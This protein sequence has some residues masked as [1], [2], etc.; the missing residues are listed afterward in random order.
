VYIGLRNLQLPAFADHGAVASTTAND[1]RD[2]QLRDTVQAA[3][4]YDWDVDGSEFMVKEGTIENHN[5]GH[6]GDKG[7]L[8]HEA[9]CRVS[10]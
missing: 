8:A 7:G 3:S 6:D 10:T 9:N 4:L 5:Y 2:V 1:D